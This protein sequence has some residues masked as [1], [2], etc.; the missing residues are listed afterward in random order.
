MAV[1]LSLVLELH[2][3]AMLIVAVEER[4][5]DPLEEILEMPGWEGVFSAYPTSPGCVEPVPPR[6]P[7]NPY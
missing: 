6:R 4:Q 3:L 5:L 7:A 2:N 1:D